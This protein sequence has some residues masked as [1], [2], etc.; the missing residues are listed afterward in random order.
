MAQF[1]GMTLTEGGRN[2][3][4]KALIGKR[5][6][7]DRVACGDGTLPDGQDLYEMTEL[8]API[9]DLP[10]AS[11][12]VTGVG[13]ATVQVVMSNEDITTPFFIRELGLFALD[14]D[15]GEE[16]LYGYCN[17]GERSDYMP[18]SGGPDVVQYLLTL[19]TVIEQ[20]QNV[21]AQ[22]TEGLAW[23]TH[24]ELEAKIKSIFG[25]SAAIADFWVRAQGDGNFLRPATLA[26]VKLAILGTTDMNSIIK[27]LDRVEDNTAENSLVLEAMG[28][29][30]DYDCMLIEDFR[31]PDTIDLY[32]CNV[33]SVVAGDDSLDCDPV[34]GMYPGSHYTI[35]DGVNYEQVRVKSVSIENAI[36][37]VILA[38]PVQ[39]TYNLST[40]RLYRTSANIEDGRA[41]GPTGT[42]MQSWAPNITWEGLGA[43]EEGLLE[44][45]TTVGSSD[46]FV[47]EGNVGFTADGL[48]TLEVTGNEI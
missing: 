4:A 5:L 33:L 38:A 17:A 23:A 47:R 1:N 18:A 31:V 20:A 8:I 28:Q 43:E 11:M 2:L 35:T 30:P 14:P 9:R 48:L 12:T 29:Y 21:T 42:G 16:I 41:T 15:T 19:V 34:A 25:D 26:D 7:F 10:I 22:I 27:R 36:Q 46:L 45:K 32:T 3:L 6:H 13:T 40:C 37:R 24:E 39:Q 44:L